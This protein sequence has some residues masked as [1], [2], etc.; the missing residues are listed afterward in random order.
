MS[1]GLKV[2]VGPKDFSGK[3]TDEK[4]ELIYQ[5]VTLQ[6]VTCVETVMGFKEACGR[7][8]HFI[9][10]HNVVT[11]MLKK[12]KNKCLGIGVGTGAIGGLSI[13]SII[14]FIKTYIFGAK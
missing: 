5:A 13:P 8:D 11:R 3:T 1:E 9:S 10:K 6:Q 7:Y 14:E 4:L 12:D 2:T